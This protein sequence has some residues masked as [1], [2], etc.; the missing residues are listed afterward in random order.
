M[1]G[2]GALGIERRDGFLYLE[3]REIVFRGPGDVTRE[4]RDI[5][6]EELAEGL[7]EIVRQNTRVEKTGL[8]QTLARQCGVS[9]AGKSMAE[10]FDAALACLGDRVRVEGETVTLA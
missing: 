8:Y 1:Q 7:L 10:S 3:G 2:C 5:A 9:R 6:V 4:I